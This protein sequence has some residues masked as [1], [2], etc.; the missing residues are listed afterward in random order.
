M[1]TIKI[2]DIFSVTKSLDT[3]HLGHAVDLYR[4]AN[5]Q[6]E[7]NSEYRYHLAMSS[8]IHSY[9]GLESLINRIGYEL[10]FNEESIK[11][12]A[13]TKRDFL[14]KRLLKSWDNVATIDKLQFILFYSGKI[15]ISGKLES[16]IRELNNYRN[17]IVHGFS[18]KE[19]FLMDWHPISDEERNNG[20]VARGMPIDQESNIDW[21]T[22]FPVTK[23]TALDSIN[24]SD[25][26]IALS[27]VFSICE[28]VCNATKTDVNLVTCFPKREYNSFPNEKFYFEE[29]IQTK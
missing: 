14:L 26:K 12:V 7:E 10:F 8:I 4:M 1:A 25:A 2:P 6:T 9:C 20:L 11:Y 5:N 29:L 19:T 23:F 13:P 3:H 27:I 28:I 24:I 18:Y 22:K 16:Q 17:W 15:E 21:E